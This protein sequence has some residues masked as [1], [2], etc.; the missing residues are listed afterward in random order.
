LEFDG[1][2]GPSDPNKPKTT[3]KG[4]LIYTKPDKA[5]YEVGGV[6]IYDGGTKKYK[7][8]ELSAEFVVVNGKEVIAK[9]FRKKQV[10]V[11]ELPK[12]LQG[13]GIFYGPLPFVFGAKATDL[14]RRYFM[15]LTTPEAAAKKGQIWLEAWPRYQADA[16]NYKRVDLIIRASDM[17]PLAIQV[18]S[19][20]G[21]NRTV[22]TFANQK[23]DPF[24]WNPFADDY[25]VRTPF[26][27]KR[28]VEKPPTGAPRRAASPARTPRR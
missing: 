19:P 1:V 14:E 20:N 15:R 5:R 22:Y 13:K 6:R 16:A 28:F 24:K 18:H 17:L 11:T 26:G 9:N 10:H 21:K 25:K 8:D 7:D 27:W 2:F 12:E 3:G 23:I 4:R